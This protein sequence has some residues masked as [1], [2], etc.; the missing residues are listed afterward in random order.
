MLKYVVK[1]KT[2]PFDIP[3]FLPLLSYINLLQYN[4]YHIIKMES[5]INI[6]LFYTL[7][8]NISTAVYPQKLYRHLVL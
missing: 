8:L 5:M 2:F 7:T 3:F 4:I 1:K 6:K